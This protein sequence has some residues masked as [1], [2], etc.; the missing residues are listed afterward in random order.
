MHSSRRRARRGAVRLRGTARPP[1]HLAR[2]ATASI[3]CKCGARAPPLAGSVEGPVRRF[4][5][6]RGR[7]RS[8]KLLSVL[9][10][11]QNAHSSAAD[12]FSLMR[13]PHGISNEVNI[14][15]SIP[16]VVSV[17]P[18][19]PNGCRTASTPC[20]R[21]DRAMRSMWRLCRSHAVAAIGDSVLTDTR[22]RRVE[23]INS[24]GVG[25]CVM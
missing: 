7:A 15:S 11:R 23:A 21:L 19:D 25:M 4:Q 9:T 14:T 2:G 24:V 22:T 20:E 17:L 5:Q 3:P 1:G 16:R 6:A 18:A 8:F 13:L 10:A 12:Q